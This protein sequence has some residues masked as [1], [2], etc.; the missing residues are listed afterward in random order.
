MTLIELSL[1]RCFIQYVRRNRA[2][3]ALLGACFLI[4]TVFLCICVKW[5]IALIPWFRVGQ[6]TGRCFTGVS[7]NNLLVLGYF[8]TPLLCVYQLR[9]ASS[10]LA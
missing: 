9:P 8:L 6:E 4:Q 7:Q 3:M 1:K 2:V 10:S 5:G